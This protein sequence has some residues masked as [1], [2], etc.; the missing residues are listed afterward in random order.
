MRPR[1]IERMTSRV[2]VVGA[3]GRMGRLAVSLI[4]REPDFEIAARLGSSDP[5]DGVAGADIV[6]DLTVPAVSP[7]IVDAALEHGIP[8]LVGTS[9]WS[10]E[11]IT[12]LRPRV[13][14]GLGVVI[15]PNFSIGSVL[16]TRF[17]ALAAPYFDSVEIVEA[18]H[19]GKVDSPS[20]TATRTAELIAAARGELGPVEA[21]HVDQRA[22]GQQVASVPVHSLRLQGVHAKQDVVFGGVGEVL[23]LTHETI[24]SASYEAGI[25]LAL[26][27]V[28][29]A[30]GVVVGLD[31][32]LDG[33]AIANAGSASEAA[34]RGP[35]ASA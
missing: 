13:P 23:T 2:A 16:A 10:A 12:S 15:V 20:G 25:L 34:H 32:L 7:Q 18:H 24:S 35:G 19:A 1:S 21:P 6:V 22:R 11:R 5:I 3:N 26:R 9:G 8:V 27:S 4:E 28:R 31:A 17:A 14:E 30:R 29:D 33:G